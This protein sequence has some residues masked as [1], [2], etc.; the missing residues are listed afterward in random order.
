MLR[1]DVSC[2]YIKNI[3][4]FRIF[5]REYVLYIKAYSFSYNTVDCITLNLLYKLLSYK[6]I[7]LY[8]NKRI[9]LSSYFKTNSRVN[10][11]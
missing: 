3:N 8:L 2:F 6:H 10:F 1:E 5:K 11:L 4:I 9:I 7:D